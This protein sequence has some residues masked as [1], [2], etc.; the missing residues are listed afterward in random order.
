[1]IDETQISKQRREVREHLT[2]EQRELEE[3]AYE[4]SRDSKWIATFICGHMIRSASDHP[5][6][7]FWQ[8]LADAKQNIVIV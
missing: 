7:T 2:P 1:M 4:A 3:W 6:W 5:D 8:V